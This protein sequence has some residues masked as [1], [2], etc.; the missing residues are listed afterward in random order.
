[1]GAAQ[2]LEREIARD[3]AVRGLLVA[4]LVVGITFAMRGAGGATGATI[5][6]AIVVGNFVVAAA[7]QAWAAARS[8]AMLGAVVLGG[9]IVRLAVVTVAILLL[10]HVAWI[11]FPAFGI[12]LAV[13]HLGLLAWEARA[14]SLTLAFP[15][16][17]PARPALGGKD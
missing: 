6:V 2:P 12:T 17:K 9:Y 11:D 13:T 16:L 14:V 10:R 8:A 1:M 4:P 7:A 5:A 3:L 15:G